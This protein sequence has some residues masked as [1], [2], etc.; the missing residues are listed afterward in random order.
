MSSSSFHVVGG[1]HVGSGGLGY[2]ASSSGF[3]EPKDEKTSVNGCSALVWPPNKSPPPPPPPN[4]LLLSE[5]AAM[6]PKEADR[7]NMLVL[8]KSELSKADRFW[9]WFAPLEGVLAVFPQSASQS[10]EA[11]LEKTPWSG[12]R[13]VVKFLSLVADTYTCKHNRTGI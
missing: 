12:D 6:F 7:S 2:E 9:Y 4:T 13:V 1:P 3:S 5:D 8:E 11:V 10:E